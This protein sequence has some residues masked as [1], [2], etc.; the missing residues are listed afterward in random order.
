MA[1][2]WHGSRRGARSARRPLDEHSIEER[3]IAYVSRYATTG[4]RLAIYL[5]RKIAE[6]GW[7][8]SA[9]PAIGE[10]VGR[11]VRLGYVDDEGFAAARASA[12]RRRGYGVR[13]IEAALR[14]AGIEPATR[15]AIGASDGDENLRSALAL[16]RRRRLGPYGNGAV[17][18]DEYRRAMAV[19]L[20][21]GHDLAIARQALAMSAEDAEQFCN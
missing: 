12:L 3:A 15:A 9:P 13:R 4:A 1:Q 7:A 16:A 2:T 6:R 21:A 14:N 11:L 5:N 18:R 19:M 20:R 17:D 10:L 8:G